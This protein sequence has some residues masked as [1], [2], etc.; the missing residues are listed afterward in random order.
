MRESDTIDFKPLESYRG[1]LMYIS[2]TY[3]AITP[4][5]KGIHLTLDSWRPWRDEDAWKLPL[6]EIKI[7]LALKDTNN[8]PTNELHDKPPLRV[9]PRLHDDILALVHL[10]SDKEPTKRT[11]QPKKCAEAMY[12]FGDASGSGFGSSLMIE[13]EIYYL[14]GQWSSTFASETSNYRELGNL[15]HAITEA[16]NKGLLKNSELFVFTDNT[17]VE[18]AFYK[19][20]SSSKRLFQL[21]LDL[22]KLQL[23][24]G[25]IL[26]L[27]HVAG[28][29]MIAQGTDGLSRGSTYQGVM[30]GTPFLKYVS[31]HQDALSRQ[32][33]TLEDW[34]LSWFSGTSSPLFLSQEDW[35]TR[36]QK[37]SSCIWTPPPAAADVALEQMACSIHKRPKHIH[38]ILIPRLFTSRW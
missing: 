22:R 16:T 20:T 13:Q 4:Y 30:A 5:L 19:G 15:L 10:F 25:F 24:G 29:R 18:S 12:M 11:I 2:R 37:H 14:H 1:F 23:H 36:G 33:P 27:I 9:A 3:P 17:T 21:V 8:M 32:G 26:H 7:A 6:S 28:Q 34:V 35:F 31:L 38:L